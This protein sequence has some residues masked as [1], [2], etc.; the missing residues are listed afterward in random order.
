LLAGRR[1]KAFSNVEPGLRLLLAS[2]LLTGRQPKACGGTAK[3][4][5]P[6]ARE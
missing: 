1:P 5:M 6:M 2:T 3:G 4:V